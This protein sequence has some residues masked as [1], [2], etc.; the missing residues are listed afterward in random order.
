MKLS[1]LKDDYNDRIG[2]LDEA[3]EKAEKT[4]KREER[5]LEKHHVALD[6]KSAQFTLFDA[7]QEKDKE[8]A[9]RFRT[10]KKLDAT[11]NRH[12]KKEETVEG[13]KVKLAAMIELRELMKS[14]IEALFDPCE[15][16]YSEV[17]GE[18][19]KAT[20]EDWMRIPNSVWKTYQDIFAPPGYRTV[21]R[22]EGI[23]D[24]GDYDNIPLDSCVI[25][26]DP[27]RSAARFAK[28][29]NLVE[30]SS[31]ATPFQR[32]Q[33]V[34]R[35]KP[36]IADVFS[37]LKPMSPY[38]PDKIADN[39][40]LLVF[41]D[42]KPEHDGKI[43]SPIFLGRTSRIQDRKVFQV[44][45]SIY[46]AHRKSLHA[47][48]SYESEAPKIFGIQTRVEAVRS[49]TVGLKKDAP[50]IAPI[51]EQIGK[52]LEILERATN[53][54][55]AE[56]SDIMKAINGIRDSLGRQNAG[57]ACAQMV[58]VLNRLEKRMPQIH[59]K[60]KAM[61]EDEK[62]LLM[63]INRA[64]AILDLCYNEFLGIC[65]VIQGYEMELS[66]NL[67][68]EESKTRK[69]TTHE[70]KMLK[71]KIDKAL[72]SL[73]C[74]ES[75]KVR[76]FNLYAAKLKEKAELIKQILESNDDD[77]LFEDSI[78]DE[79][80]EILRDTSIKAFIIS[81]IFKVQQEKERILKEI[82]L[83]PDDTLIEVLV[84]YAEELLIV[85]A[86]RQVYPFVE[87]SYK[88]QYRDIQKRVETLVKGLK[89]HIDRGLDEKEKAQERKEMYA[90][91]KCYLEEINFPEILEEL[92]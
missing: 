23:F 54:F 14:E 9:T 28:E 57:K 72:G 8:A 3:I 19:R 89:I 7:L 45:D 29:F 58:A 84:K 61:G 15:S 85:V 31:D 76:P 35:A 6:K 67:H 49:Q 68:N 64:E 37:H 17:K 10:D 41:R 51:C 34:L 5:V 75:L 63:R 78:K 40:R 33:E 50:E 73:K 69:P 4:L 46:N 65:N 44:F 55:K 91:L 82:T 20:N 16:Q 11:E 83:M 2:K 80:L 26:P 47:S 71:E 87:T 48:K 60:S 77:S 86:D 59:E 25:D 62:T 38:G 12:R 39:Y 42:Y 79:D 92:D 24:G 18:F 21:P 90:R 66:P 81:K 22:D 88:F 53:H 30:L 74:I 13:L 27:K 43:I 1:N 52:E 36:E 32:M 70:V 56:A